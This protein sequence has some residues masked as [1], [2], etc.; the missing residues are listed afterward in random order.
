MPDFGT[1]SSDVT[2]LR[3]RVKPGQRVERGQPLMEIET[4][5]STMVVESVAT[6]VVKE[7]LVECD[8]SVEAGQEIAVIEVEAPQE[9]SPEVKP[10]PTESATSAS[11]E[12]AEASPSPTVQKSARGG[13]FAR[14][15][16]QKE[17][18]GSNPEAKPS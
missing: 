3:W 7:F 8:E 4:D 13:L 14:N 12:R 10:T 5:K 15:R 18:E 1:T 6:G 16:A 17:A 2:V 9:S 11:A